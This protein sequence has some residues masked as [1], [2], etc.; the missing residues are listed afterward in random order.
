MTMTMKRCRDLIEVGLV[1]AMLTVLAC[2]SPESDDDLADDD[3]ADDDAGDDDSADDDTANDD[4]DTAPPWTGWD[5]IAYFFTLDIDGLSGTGTAEVTLQY[6]H[7]GGSLS[8]CEQ[9]MLFDAAL[10]YGP[11]IGDDFWVS[12]DQLVTWAGPGV[13]ISNECD[14]DPEDPYGEGWDTAF[15]W[16][17]NPLGFVSCEQISTEPALNATDV[18]P[19]PFG[20][21]EGDPLTFGQMCEEVGPI[22]AG[23]VGT[24]DLEAVWLLP[25]PDGWLDGF[26]NYTYFVPADTTNVET[27][28]LF[29]YLMNDVANLAG[30]GIDGVCYSIS[31]LVV[32]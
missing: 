24:G 26:G 16:R 8:P 20:M 6:H 30:P 22:L 5:W 14:W 15:Y 7:S 9:V 27:W 2:D 11:G 23:E 21:V 18:G 13:L 19:D 25:M 3:L 12:I 1:L 29:G 4:D 31:F 10:T 17:F 28:G 32:G